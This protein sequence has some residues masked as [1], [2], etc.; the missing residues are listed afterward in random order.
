[1]AEP[2][3]LLICLNE[4]SSTLGRKPKKRLSNKTK[5]KSVID[6]KQVNTGDI[7]PSS[8][9]IAESLATSHEQ[10]NGDEPPNDMYLECPEEQDTDRVSSNSSPDFN[11][12]NDKISP[13]QDAQPTI[14]D[15]CNANITDDEKYRQINTVLNNNTNTGL[16]LTFFIFCQ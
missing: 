7:L 5:S 12:I 13:A 15:N 14:S 8:I 6:F 11:D 1:M 4:L 10:T 2:K 16:A 3:S 9:S